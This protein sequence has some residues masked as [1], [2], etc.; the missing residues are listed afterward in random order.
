MELEIIAENKGKMRLSM[1]ALADAIARRYATEDL[2]DGELSRA[3]EAMRNF[4]R[5]EAARG[6]A[7]YAHKAGTAKNAPW[8]FEDRSGQRKR[9]AG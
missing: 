1:N 8:E 3:R 7:P 2:T 9:A 4:L 5:K 6:L